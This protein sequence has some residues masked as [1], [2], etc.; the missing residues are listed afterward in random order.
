LTFVSRGAKL[1]KEK[2]LKKPRKTKA[3]AKE[4]T[5]VPTTGTSVAAEPEAVVTVARSS[6]AIVPE[7]VVTV[8]DRHPPQIVL[9][10]EV[11]PVGGEETLRRSKRVRREAS[12]SAPVEEDA[13]RPEEPVVGEEPLA[14]EGVEVQEEHPGDDD[15]TILEEMP[16][17]GE[18]STPVVGDL[19]RAQARIDDCL[20]KVNI[21]CLSF[22]HLFIVL[23]PIFC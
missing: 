8:L 10:E 7:V 14:D 9:E 20:L 17:R 3:K 13:Q 22:V 2:G 23:F 21:A 19:T 16:L 6:L 12:A 4:P 5:G 1:A 18:T 15:V 11:S